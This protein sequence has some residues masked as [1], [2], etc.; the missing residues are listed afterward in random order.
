MKNR[1]MVLLPLALVLSACTLAEDV[2]PPPGYDATQA[3]M[4]TSPPVQPID[5]VP[6]GPP[7]PAAG[8]AI[9]AE[10]CA[11][12]HG[13]LGRGDGPQA[14]QL[15][16]QPTALGDPSVAREAI[17]AD[18]YQVVTQG[19]LDQMMPPFASLTDAQRWDVVAY[20]LGL[21]VS[22][23]D[24]AQ[25]EADYQ[26]SC[27]SCHGQDGATPTGGVVLSD[28]GWMAKQSQASM[29]ASI[30]Q[31]SGDMPGFADKLSESQLWGMSAYVRQFAF[32]AAGAPAVASSAT[33][34]PT[35]SSGET[36]SIV[37]TV[38]M[39]S[40]SSEGSP[41]ADLEITLHGYD[42]QQ[43]VV[44]QTETLGTSGSVSFPD[45]DIVSGRLFILSTEYKGVRY[46][47]D[48]S[49]L[50]DPGQMI[51]LPLT[52]YDLTSDTS[53][54]SASRLHILLDFPS[55]GVMQV[56]EL[57]VLSNAGDHT[58]MASDSGGLVFS[59][60]AGA[61]NIAFEDTNVAQMATRT[62]DGF[63]LAMP[64][65]PGQETAQLVFSFNLPYDSQVD[66]YQPLAY[67]VD[68]VTVLLPDG[69]P[70]VK[71]ATVEDQGVQNLGGQSYH[72]YNL[73]S[74][75]AGG[76]IDMQVA[77]G[78]SPVVSI[79]S[80]WPSL[81]LGAAALV[82]VLAGVLAWYR[83]SLLGFGPIEDDELDSDKE[84]EEEDQD[85]PQTLV[86][87]IARL[88]DAFEAGDIDEETYK[89]RRADL[90]R[91]ALD[92]MTSGDD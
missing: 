22:A 38:S 14:A 80:N 19:R 24:L 27:A 64:L 67:P 90:K 47:S 3:A 73:Q 82:L 70:T 40:G 86:A 37:A 69:G 29:V 45:L 89:R 7:N 39:G 33:G 63:N 59:L 57:W 71:G 60:P 6:A 54:V 76:A 74:F 61:N 55:D 81:A 5:L 41:P 49:H 13:D 1:W 78:T 44:T 68:G 32:S 56:Y 48:V 52:I 92:A 83:P 46:V 88:D 26:E 4:P 66:F 62:N 87:N 58:V 65:T 16:N 8:Q 72:Q 85:D 84:D 77:G 21:N 11:P 23:D 30:S 18:W 28:P 79:G 36:A 10:R 15:P 53:N 43:E 31:G 51:Q 91:R 34:T 35:P 9:Y 50:T 25:A 75:S 2:T 20:S 12:C 17:P 42:G